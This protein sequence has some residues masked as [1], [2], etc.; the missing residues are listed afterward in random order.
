M[1]ILSSNT[2]DLAIHVGREYHEKTVETT[3]L[4]DVSGLRIESSR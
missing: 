3:V 4:H 1:M 2:V